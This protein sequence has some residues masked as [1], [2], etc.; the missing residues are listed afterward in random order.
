M[1]NFKH[2]PFKNLVAVPQMTKKVKKNG[3][4][5][6]HNFDTESSFCSPVDASRALSTNASSHD[7]ISSQHT[8]TD[9]PLLVLLIGVIVQHKHLH[10]HIILIWL[11]L[12]RFPTREP[13]ERL[14]IDDITL[15]LQHNRLR[16]YGPVLREDDDDWVK[17]YMEYEAE[18]PTPRGR[19]KRTWTE[20]VE[21]DCQAPK[22]NTEDAIDRSR[23]RKL[24]KDV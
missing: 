1:Y 12:D 18:G 2:S 24:I 7:A 11:I 8:G 21:K 16:W 5:E 9:H 19:P 13:R 20:V 14:G 10:Q 3:Q 22:L 17:K 6:A 4:K 15:V 23:W